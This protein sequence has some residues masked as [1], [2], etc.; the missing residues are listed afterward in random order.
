MWH[1]LQRALCSRPDLPL[2]A[3][4]YQQNHC[5]ILVEARDT[6]AL[7]GVTH[8]SI[9]WALL[10]NAPQA[11]DANKH[12]KSNYQREAYRQ[13]LQKGPDRIVAEERHRKKQR[14]WVLQVP[15]RIGATRALTLFK[16]LPLLVRPRVVTSLARTHW[17]GWCTR[18]R[19]Q[20]VG[21]CVLGCS[22]RADDSIE[23]Y[24]HCPVLKEMLANF[25]HLPR[26]TSMQEFLL[27]DHRLWSD[28][29][30]IVSAVS[31]HVLY[32]TFNHARLTG[33]H[34]RECLHDYMERSCY[35]A[36]LNHKRSQAALNLAMSNSRNWFM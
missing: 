24:L 12:V 29:R 17:N 15:A 3:E 26:F 32:T 19:F 7:Y 1:N 10:A 13:L 30:L 11:G 23:H 2:V 31:V 5:K 9:V 6:A 33:P 16:R 28:S 34:S 14:R 20:Q 21:C 35:H 18:R 25:L 36:V 22:V 27:L 4:W 8:D